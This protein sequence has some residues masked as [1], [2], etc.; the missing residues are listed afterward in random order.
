MLFLHIN[1]LSYSYHSF[2][3]TSWIYELSKL[4]IWPQ[5]ICFELYKT[6]C[7][8]F[9]SK[10]NHFSFLFPLSPSN[11]SKEAFI[12]WARYDDSQDHFCELDGNKINHSNEVILTLILLKEIEIS[13][14]IISY[15]LNTLDVAMWILLFIMAFI[16]SLCSRPCAERLKY[17]ISDLYS[18][19]SKCVFFHIQGNSPKKTNLPRITQ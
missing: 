5:I 2:K 16:E 3:F 17:I 7:N 4:K 1:I 19:L 13:E 9:N 14:N 8:I 15:I 12:D 18:Y 11:Q 6:Q 10:F